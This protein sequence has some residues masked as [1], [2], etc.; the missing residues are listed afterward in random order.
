M[1]PCNSAG[2]VKVSGSVNERFEEAWKFPFMTRKLILAFALMHCIFVEHALPQAFPAKDGYTTDLYT[3][4]PNSTTTCCETY[5]VIPDTQIKLRATGSVDG[6]VRQGFVTM[7]LQMRM[8]LSE[9]KSGLHEYREAAHKW[10]VFVCKLDNPMCAK[11]PDLQFRLY[12]SPDNW[13]IQH[14]GVARCEGWTLTGFYPQYV[15]DLKTDPRLRRSSNA[16]PLSI[17]VPA[18][19]T[20]SPY[21]VAEPCVNGVDTHQR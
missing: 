1:N 12:L 15:K 6:T 7:H 8:E 2:H 10:L 16:I 18:F 13:E 17:T 19:L 20:R 11:L 3:K 9:A 14:S 21:D 4:R 5:I